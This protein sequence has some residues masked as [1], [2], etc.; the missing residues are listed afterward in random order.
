MRWHYRY[1]DITSVSHNGRLVLDYSKF[2]DV[3]PEAP[4]ADDHDRPA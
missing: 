4:D 3:V 2:H 1:R